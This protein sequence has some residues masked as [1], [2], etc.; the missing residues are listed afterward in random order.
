[1]AFNSPSAAKASADLLDQVL[2]C[3]PFSFDLATALTNHF[4]FS[5]WAHFAPF[6]GGLSHPY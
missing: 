4:G 5:L 1:M 2:D 3:L 6:P